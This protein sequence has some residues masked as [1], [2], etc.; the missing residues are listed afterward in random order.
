M[1]NFT[2]TY[3]RSSILFLL[4]YFRATDTFCR[5][6]SS[7]VPKSQNFHT[8]QTS[9]TS[10]HRVVHRRLHIL[11]RV[12]MQNILSPRNH[13]SRRVATRRLFRR[14]PRRGFTV[15][16]AY[17]SADMIPWRLPWSLLSTTSYKRHWVAQKNICR[18][19]SD[20]YFRASDPRV[21]LLNSMFF[22]IILKDIYIEI[23]LY[24]HKKKRIVK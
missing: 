18:K 21:F 1:T 23:D 8:K 15:Y 4:S 22:Q 19:I 2:C 17:A 13:V 9:A 24:L 11:T 16:F 20:I 10:S 3:I 14:L 7:F 6:V 5:A 12:A